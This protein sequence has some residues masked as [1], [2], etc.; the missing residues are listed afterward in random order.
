MSNLSE[1]LPSG[2]GQ[3]QVEF[4]ASGTLPNG[5]PV[6]LNSNGTVT[7]VGESSTSVSQSIP[8]GSAVEITNNG[9]ADYVAF[10]QNAAGKFVVTYTDADNSH[11][12]TA[13]VGSV[14]GTS[15]SFGSAYVFAATQANP[16]F[17]A[18]DPNT[19]GKFVITYRD[20]SNGSGG[21]AIVGT[22]SGTSISFGSAVV[23]EA[24]GT[25][26][27]APIS[28]DPNTA[29]K[30]VIAYSN[31]SSAA[32]IG[33][34]KVG[35]VSGTSISF[36]SAVV[37]NTAVTNDISVSIDP[38]TA[39]KF[40]VAYRDHGNSHRGTVNVGTISG[41]SISFGSKVVFTT[42]RSDFNSLSFDPNTANKFVIAYHDDANSGY[43]TAIVGT[44]S[45]TS[46]SFG[47]AAVFNSA[48]TTP[49]R[50]SFDPSTAGKFV[51]VYRDYTSSLYYGR[52]SVGT[53]SG[54][55]ISF[56]S[57]FAFVSAST[58]FTYM[59]FDP[60]TAGK[61]VVVFVDGG[62]SNKATAILGQIAATVTATNLT[63][64]N[65]IGIAAAAA[66]SGATAKI[67]TWG[68]INEA[69][70][71][72]TI[73]SDYYV[74][75]DGRIAA[76]VENT[77]YDISSATYDS[78]VFNTGSQESASEGL[79]FSVDGTK[80]YTVGSGSDTVYEYDLATA[81]DISTAAYNS[82]SF[83]VASQETTPGGLDFSSD[84]TKMY[85]AGYTTDTVFQYTLS[86]AFDLSTASYAS[87][88]FN[89]SSQENGLQ[90]VV[91]NSDGSK[92]Y[93]RG[94]TNNTFFQ[95][96]LSTPYNVSTASYDSV[97]FTPTA[98]GS[99]PIS[100]AFNADGTKCFVA[101]ANTDAIFQYSLSSA[102]NVGTASYDSISLNIVNQNNQPKDIAFSTDGTRLFLIGQSGGSFVY[103]YSTTALAY[104]TTV[105]VGQAISA[106]TINMRNQP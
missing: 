102:Y 60:N 23:F 103:Q 27:I 95:Y 82:V 38:N 56:G 99:Q 14:S 50:A 22:V 31:Y 13:I 76:G 78:K 19:A 74:Q 67:N 86:T 83:S 96:S 7:V 72:L 88:S 26:E 91:F 46:A 104:S 3:N 93:I 34:A 65:L 16:I 63:A 40:V 85:I 52:A 62:N 48:N 17:I 30:F 73:A 47:T 29:N 25:T 10:D 44:V 43:G 92:M 51:A 35:T 20:H 41:T 69:Q 79:A 101:N 77:P 24:G 8:A 5:K 89:V 61:F 98:Q 2:G 53:V 59:A 94:F 9:T 55:S 100:L 106:T 105:K 6:I 57:K 39:N 18:F 71:S 21:T 70:S 15:I 84:G 90:F 64:T 54:T 49:I 11:F 66:S 12:G 97:T 4:V 33:T 1:L 68:G 28:F 80:M 81:F 36:G 87:I 45:G 42:N 37:F 58:N 32:E 75:D